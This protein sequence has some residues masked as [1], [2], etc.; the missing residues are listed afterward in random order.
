M[1]H[2]Q[3]RTRYVSNP[4]NILSASAVATMDSILFALE[5]KTG[6]QTLVV[7]VTGIEGGDCF[8]FAYRLGKEMESVKRNVTMAWSSF[9]LPMNDAYSSLQAMVWKVYCL[10]LFVSVSKADTW[11]NTLAR[12]I[13]T[14]VW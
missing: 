8:D 4:D 9:F 10:T 7:V 1:V 2:L 6:I 11:W 3:D 13:G 5:Q 12:K 14:P